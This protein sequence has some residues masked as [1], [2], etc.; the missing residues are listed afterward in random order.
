G[1]TVPRDQTTDLENRD[2]DLLSCR[3]QLGSQSFGPCR[4]SLP[5][6]SQGVKPTSILLSV[7]C[8]L[9]SST[10]A[11]GG[12]GQSLDGNPFA[13]TALPVAEG[14]EEKEAWGSPAPL[15]GPGAVCTMAWTP[16][17]LVLLSHCTGSLSQPVLTQPS[18]LSASP[19]ASARLTCTLSSGFG[20]DGY[21]IYWYQQK[22]GNPPWHLL[23]YYSDSDK[24]QG[25]MVPSRFS[26]SRDA[27]ANAGFC[28]PL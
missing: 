25:S 18:P 6:L 17:L 27:S 15:W 14:G 24:D 9:S 8:E 28:S 26:G 21:W 2:S 19:G 10:R 1:I 20:V 23:Y 12:A 7:W 22:P 13:W 16:L 4:R 5:G 3:S 11:Q